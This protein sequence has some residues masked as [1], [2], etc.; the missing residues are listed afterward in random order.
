[1][2][3][4]K[5]EKAVFAKLST[6]K[7]E[8]ASVNELKSLTSKVAQESKEFKSLASKGE[9]LSKE[10][11]EIARRYHTAY[12]ELNNLEEKL[13]NTV[14]R[15]PKNTLELDGVIVE[16]ARKTKELGL[17]TPNELREARRTYQENLEYYEDASS[18]WQVLMDLQEKYKFPF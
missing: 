18:V 1:M 2:K 15:S 6:Q 12:K 4:G 5:T 9:S 3:Q 13:S 16:F 17:D 14:G 7:V 8:L 11:D 10:F